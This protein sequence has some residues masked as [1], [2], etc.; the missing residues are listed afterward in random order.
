M[1]GHPPSRVRLGN[2]HLS[3]HRY[4]QARHAA[5][6]VSLSAVMLT[7]TTL[8]PQVRRLKT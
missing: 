4:S 8:K 3:S 5:W 1:L 6:T 7:Q 2:S